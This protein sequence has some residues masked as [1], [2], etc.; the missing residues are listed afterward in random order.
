ML[1][2]REMNRRLRDDRREYISIA[3]YASGNN[4]FSVSM[5]TSVFCCMVHMGNVGVMLQHGSMVNLLQ[6]MK[7]V[8][9]KMSSKDC[10]VGITTMCF[11][12]HVVEVSQMLVEGGFSSA[13][14]F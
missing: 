8:L 11:D 5:L 4:G 13:N 9:P 7:T 6:S 1:V 14:P 10:I 12:I 3:A 2:L